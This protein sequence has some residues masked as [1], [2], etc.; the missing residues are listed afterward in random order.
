M[1]Q[2]ESLYHLGVPT[3]AVNEYGRIVFW[4]RYAA[5]FFHL[6]SD[7]A[8]GREWHT[9]VQSVKTPECCVLCWTRQ[10]L[11]RGE[12]A[13]PLD[14]I[15]FVAGCRQRVVMVPI[16]SAIDTSANITFL[17][18]DH[19]LAVNVHGS[20]SAPVPVPSGVLRLEED[21]VI[22]DLTTRE[23]DILACVAEGLDA[24]GIAASIGISHATARNYVQ[25]LLTKLC[26]RNKAEAVSIALTHNLLT[27]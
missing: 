25:Q 11:R 26:A 22:V 9:V 17:I 15:V 10:A 21:R 13:R 18:I 23:R 20:V 27:G 3:I 2:L 7:L 16:P 1:S 19:G 6:Q 14:S 12:A 4:N 24:R 5:N 8:V